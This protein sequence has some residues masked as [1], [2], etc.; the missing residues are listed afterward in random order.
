MASTLPVRFGIRAKVKNPWATVPPKG[1]SLAARSTFMW[2]HWWSPV[3]SANLL[4]VP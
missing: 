3:A 2:I 4:I 1:D